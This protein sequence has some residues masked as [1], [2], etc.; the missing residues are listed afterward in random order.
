MAN[1][2]NN[3][4]RRLEHWLGSRRFAAMAG[5]ALCG[6]FGAIS[7]I[8]PPAIYS[9]PGW[10]FTAWQGTLLGAT[11]STI[12]PDPADISRDLTMFLS[13]WSPGQYLFPGALTLIGLPLGAAI[14]FVVTIASVLFFLGWLRVVETFSPN[15]MNFCAVLVML[16]ALRFATLSFGIYTGGEVLLQAATPWIILGAFLVPTSSALRAGIITALIVIMAFLAK[17]SGLIV[18][19]AALTGACIV[20]LNTERKISKGIIG[21]VIGSVTALAAIYFFFLSRSATPVSGNGMWQLPW[22]RILIAA[23]LPWVAAFSWTDLMAWLFIHPGRPVFKDAESLVWLA[24]PI[25]IFMIGIIGSWSPNTASERALKRFSFWFYGATFVA[26]AFLYLR[27]SNIGIEERYFRQE[28]MLFLTCAFIAVA[29][30][31]LRWIKTSFF[32]LLAAMSL[33]GLTSFVFHAS[34]SA[35]GKS[36][37][38]HSWTNQPLV[39]TAALDFMRQAYVRDGRRSLF[40]LPSVDNAVALPVGARVLVTSLDFTP[41]TKIAALRYSGHV[42]GTLFVLMQNDI[43]DGEKGHHMLAAFRGYRSRNWKRIAFAKSSIFFQT[44]PR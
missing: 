32:A 1:H 18:A 38:R 6:L 16:C 28:G 27:G 9:D 37:D 4:S 22:T 23:I 15:A 30:S 25:A 26:F 33:Y 21:G 24:I 3:F 42:P 35:S 43:A 13:W 2:S 20:Y 10:G 17:L 39:D 12:T 5:I 44:A 11:N 8:I 29:N 14:I 36:L 34:D 41:D 19:A 40:V 31:R 7:L